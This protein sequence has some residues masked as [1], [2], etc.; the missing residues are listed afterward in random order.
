M[1][2]GTAS[3]DK[4]VISRESLYAPS[5]KEKKYEMIFIGQSVLDRLQVVGFIVSESHQINN[6][7]M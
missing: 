7:S 5:G 2:A 4:E 3:P 1:A 6:N